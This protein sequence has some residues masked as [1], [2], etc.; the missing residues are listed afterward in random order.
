MDL[1][2]ACGG[3][4]RTLPRATLYKKGIPLEMIT[5]IR[6]G[7]KNTALAPKLKNKYGEPALNNVGVLRG[8][9][10][11][12]PRFIIYQDDAMADYYA[13]NREAEIPLKHTEERALTEVDQEVRN[14]IRREFENKTKRK[15]ANL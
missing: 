14:E 3:V 13:L 8:S 10:I 1:T 15:S 11:N 7:R 4:N 9:A 5:H 12:A 2:Q 6:R